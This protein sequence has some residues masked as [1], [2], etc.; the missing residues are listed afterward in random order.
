VKARLEVRSASVLAVH[1][2]DQN[3]GRHWRPQ[4][5]HSGAEIESARKI[6]FSSENWFAD[7][8]TKVE[9]S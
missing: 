1:V 2:G 3:N 8:S 6:L 7:R 4:D 5:G 9:F